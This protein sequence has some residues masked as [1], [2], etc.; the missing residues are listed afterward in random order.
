M[1]RSY[2]CSRVL[3]VAFAL[4]L[5]PAV[6]VADPPARPDPYNYGYHGTLEGDPPTWE[7]DPDENDGSYNSTTHKLTMENVAD[8][9]HIKDVWLHVKLECP[10]VGPGYAWDWAEM[11]SPGED[12]WVTEG[13][14]GHQWTTSG[15]GWIHE[16]YQTWAISPQPDSETIDI[17]NL[18]GAAGDTLLELECYTGCSRLV[19]D[20]G[21][22]SL[23]AFGGLALLA[24][25]RA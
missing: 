25:R 19:P 7:V 14:G 24:R 12:Y 16:V 9:T 4:V 18:F 11:E 23:L 3:P 8:P 22:L 5:I 20:P 1:N 10:D 6:A 13:A 21:T 15:D 17:S 2:C